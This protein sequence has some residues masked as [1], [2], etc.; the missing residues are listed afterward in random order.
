MVLS[1]REEGSQPHSQQFLP[2]TG[3]GIVGIPLE[4]S[5]LP[6]EVDQSYQWAVVLVCG[7]RPSP[8]DPVVT[9]W[10]RRV[11]APGESPQDALERAVWYGE[12]GVWY[13]ALTA[14]VEV[15]RSQ[16]TDPVFTEIW[17]N[18]LMQPSVGLGAIANEPL[19]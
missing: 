13:D 12:Q 17:V 15:R 10:V 9:A 5:A 2:I 6:L 14:L 16:P 8:N 7:D 1:I 19:Q 11:A 4:E 18:F 3:S